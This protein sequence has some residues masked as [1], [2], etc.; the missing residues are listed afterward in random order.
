MPTKDCMSGDPDRLNPK[1]AHFVSNM[2]FL[3]ELSLSFA[4]IDES[5]LNM[6][7]DVLIKLA[8][9]LRQLE[10]ISHG[11]LDH[12]IQLF[13]SVQSISSQDDLSIIMNK[14]MTEEMLVP[15]YRAFAIA[16]SQCTKLIELNLP[17]KMLGSYF[18]KTLSEQTQAEG[19]TSDL[20]KIYKPLSFLSV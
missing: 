18:F 3:E 9:S 7:A 1:M 8:P 5:W 12:Q 14:K 16:V 15:K 19:Y 20:I 4:Y 11:Q 10:I 2:S 6:F 13:S 17:S